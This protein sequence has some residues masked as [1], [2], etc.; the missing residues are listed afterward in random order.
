MKPH[1]PKEELD[2]LKLKQYE[3]FLHKLY[4]FRNV[5]LDEESLQKLLRNLD[6]LFR[7]TSEWENEEILYSIYLKSLK[8]LDKVPS[9]EERP[10]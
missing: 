6:A 9:S 10:D 5:T 1:L 2:Q 3:S 7:S 8:D 4:I